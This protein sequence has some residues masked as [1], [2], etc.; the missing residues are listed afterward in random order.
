VRLTATRQIRAL[1]FAFV[2]AALCIPRG[3]RAAAAP[4]FSGSYTLKSANG[5]GAPD[6]REVWTLQITQTEAEIT[7]VTAID[8]HPS[9]EAF[10]LTDNERTCR[11]ADGAD[12]KCSGQWKGK[13]LVLETVYTAH[14]T[15][16]GPDVEMHARER[17]DLSADRKTLTI[18]TDTKAPQFPALEMSGATRE[19][20]AR[21]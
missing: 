16:N 11:N 13:T 17:L 8:G 19:I 18:R 3:A 9:T 10:P 2:F 12:A 20:Y 4:D 6:K 15:E 14:P 5:T 1:R 21:R 7:I